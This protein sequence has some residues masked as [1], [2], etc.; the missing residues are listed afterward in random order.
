MK[1]EP[2]FSESANAIFPALFHHQSPA[3]IVLLTGPIFGTFKTGALCH[4]VLE[5][6]RKNSQKP[7]SLYTFKN[8]NLK[9]WVPITH[10]FCLKVRFFHLLFHFKRMTMGKHFISCDFFFGH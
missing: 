3:K 2:E 7:S 5:K 10:C 8:M 6:I 1:P 9:K 4:K